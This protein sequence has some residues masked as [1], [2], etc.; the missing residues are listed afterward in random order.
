[1]SP[2]VQTFANSSAYGYRA[3]I[4]AVETDYQSIA[5][6]TVGSGGSSTVTFSSIPST[7]QHLQI[8][9]IV[10]DSG[11]GTAYD[12]LRANSD[13]GSNYS[14]H[15]LQGNGSTTAASAGATQTS[16]AI[17]EYPGTSYT[18]TIF[19][20]KIIEI[21][22]YA[23]TNKYKTV[24]FFSSWDA[25]GSGGGVWFGSGSWQSTSA[26]TSLTF[27]AGNTYAQETTFALYGIKG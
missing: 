16:I 17:L 14:W 8:R 21:L 27:I 23:N 11:T 25:N 18:S 13:T 10:R 19:G 3:F 9:A 4:P 15:Y 24:R 1:M 7:F 2:I 5:T 6:V 12:N 22:D 20:G 26:I